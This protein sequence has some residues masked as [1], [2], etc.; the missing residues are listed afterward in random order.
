MTGSPLG[1]NP[2][3]EDAPELEPLPHLE[4][5]ST[6]EPT[7]S[8]VLPAT[9]LAD[10]MLSD[11]AKSPR[12]TQIGS[13]DIVP[14]VINE[15]AKDE[16][17][18][19]DLNNKETTPA[20]ELTITKS[21]NSEE[22]ASEF[23]SFVD[24]AI[25]EST[26][27]QS[28]QSKEVSSEK[29]KPEE[30]KIDSA[31]SDTKDD[32]SPIKGLDDAQLIAE[33][34]M[35]APLQTDSPPS[36]AKTAP[37]S[38]FPV[39]PLPEQPAKQP[40]LSAPSTAGLEKK[41]DLG[42]AKALPS[43][44]AQ[45]TVTGP[46]EAKTAP[47]ATASTTVTGPSSTP[48]VPKGE[49]KVSS[50]IKTKVLRRASKPVKPE[51]SVLAQSSNPT[52]DTAPPATYQDD[53][54]ST[55]SGNKLPDRDVNPAPKEPRAD[56]EAIAEAPSD[57]ASR[58]DVPDAEQQHD[59]ASSISSLSTEDWTRGRSEIRREETN[60]SQ[61]EDYEEARDHFDSQDLA[62]PT[63]FKETTRVSDSPV[64]DSKFLEDL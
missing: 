39:S 45:T 61:S 42:E 15:S 14:T 26:H 12:S 47:S 3:S 13:E 63:A 48:K 7:L 46:S 33:R 18:D 53:P 22:D 57:I 44:P 58:K 16:S 55:I 49:S 19:R 6:G 28:S 9:L 54:S 32:S 2:V 24:P 21:S 41:R 36:G 51:A 50:W 52:A 40:T 8:P 38:L 35:S 25:L 62:P 37:Q 43:A 31:A 1:E 11:D 59:K 23:E 10:S 20:N 56:N 60:V 17:T 30:P 29:D 34:A 4:P 64:R 5:I 27:D